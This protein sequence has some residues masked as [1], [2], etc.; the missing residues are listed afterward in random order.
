MRAKGI[1]HI[2]SSINDRQALYV[3]I[4]QI[5]NDGITIRIYG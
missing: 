5:R 1:C 2:M 3:G 4:G